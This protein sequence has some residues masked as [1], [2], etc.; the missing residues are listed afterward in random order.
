MRSRRRRA[1]HSAGERP[2]L[3]GWLGANLCE[4]SFWLLAFTVRVA[5]GGRQTNNE[6]RGL[7]PP[8]R[9]CE[10]KTFVLPV[11]HCHLIHSLAHGVR[12]NLAEFRSDAGTCKKSTDRH[13][14]R[15]NNCLCSNLGLAFVCGTD[16]ALTVSQPCGF[17]D[18]FNFDGYQPKAARGISYEVAGYARVSLG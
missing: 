4:E 18:V 9:Q 5:C 10:W 11:W 15:Y 16:F 1:R 12:V 7:T 8:A 13:I 17:G 6:T 2:A 14:F 3:A